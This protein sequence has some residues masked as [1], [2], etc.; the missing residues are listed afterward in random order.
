MSVNTTNHERA[1]M[2]VCTRD[3]VMAPGHLGKEGR[4]NG[5]LASGVRIG[6]A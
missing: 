2:A 5:N 6:P 4:V 3:L 1:A